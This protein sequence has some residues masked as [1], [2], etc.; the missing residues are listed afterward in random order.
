MDT[1]P[2]IHHSGPRTTG[3][4]GLFQIPIEVINVPS[5]HDNPMIDLMTDDADPLDPVLTSDQTDTILVSLEEQTL[6][7]GDVIQ[8]NRLASEARQLNSRSGINHGNYYRNDGKY[9]WDGFKFL[10]L[11]SDIDDYG[12]LPSVFQVITNGYPSNYWEDAIEHNNIAW[13]DVGKIQTDLLKNYH[14]TKNG[15][16]ITHFQVDSQTYYL[17]NG[18]ILPEDGEC[19]CR[20]DG[21]D[22]EDNGQHDVN[23]D[24]PEPVGCFT[25]SQITEDFVLTTI[26]K[27][28]I[29]AIEISTVNPKILHLVKS[30]DPNLDEQ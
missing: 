22:D 2:Q 14:T 18:I 26:R 23:D 29:A 6:Q 21:E 16:M 28:G 17:T 9:V 4:A 3:K 12:H 13:L 24:E 25:S 5:V 15:G 19:Y 8:C 10:R 30:F 7:V 1:H 20:R 27:G 11:V